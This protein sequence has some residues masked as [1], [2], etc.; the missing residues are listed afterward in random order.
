MRSVLAITGVAMG[1]FLVTTLL[2]VGAGVT[3]QITEQVSTI[4][5]DVLVVNAR[6]GNAP[7]DSATID[8]LSKPTLTLDDVDTVRT[9][10][11]V[12]AVA[13]IRYLGGEIG[14]ADTQTTPT[15]IAATSHEYDDVRMFSMKRGRFFTAEDQAQTVPRVVIGSATEKALFSD[16]DPIG[17][18]ITYEGK[19]LLVVGVMSEQSSSSDA[20]AANNI[21]NTVYGPSTLVDDVSQEYFYNLIMARIDPA[22]AVQTAKEDIGKSLALYKDTDSYAIR[23]EEDRINTSETI[24]TVVKAFVFVVGAVSLIISGVV[25]MN[26]MIVSVTD[27]T[28]EIGVRKTV[29]ASSTNIFAQFLIE[30]LIITFTG[31]LIGLLLS[32]VAVFV[33][34]R[35]AP[36]DPRISGD[37]VL[38]GICLSTTMGVLF[39]VGPAL[40][41]ARK[42]AI[43]S[44]QTD[45]S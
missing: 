37:V 9:E 28:R 31:G 16:I 8:G 33:V 36:I 44:L 26:S 40:S 6:S 13:P 25:V 12:A 32:V 14:Y 39:G 30:A 10:P 11:T 4:G 19:E 2:F 7:D 27:R 20:I 5:S 43:T 21:D 18:V 1:I 34:A 24:L 29:G 42:D 23:T 45:R 15:F 38:L 17:K 41:A 3:E 22:S 35:F